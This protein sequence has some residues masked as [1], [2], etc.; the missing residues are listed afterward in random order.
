[1]VQHNTF[2]NTIDMPG[3]HGARVDLA[4]ANSHWMD[5]HLARARA[6]RGVR[7]PRTIVVRPTVDRATYATEPGD[8][9][10][11][12]NLRMRSAGDVGR[13][14]L[15]KGGE[16]FWACARRMPNMKF[17]GVT[18][19][20]GEQ[21]P[22]DLPNVEL[23][24]HVPNPAM[25][26]LVYARTRVLLMPS[27]YESWGRVATEATAAGIPVIASPT[28]GLMENLGEAGIFVDPDDVDGYVRA[29]RTL[30]M[31]GP[32]AA[33]RKRA[34]ARA[35]EHEAM[36]LEDEARWVSEVERLARRPVFAR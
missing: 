27:S 21:A 19:A 17:L 26:D 1:V 30:A 13:D 14:A 29:L 11:L 22:G 32:Y 7:Q 20:Y 9:V 8:R 35:A 5:G 10:T 34:L 12:V 25:R 4:V 33:A 3:L 24:D 2:D 31:P 18:G 6:A 15:T 28:P 16:V 23:L 36:Q